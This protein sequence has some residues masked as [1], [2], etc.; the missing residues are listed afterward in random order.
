[1]ERL[2]SL[3]VGAEGA[4]DRLTELTRHSEPEIRRLA[5]ETLERIM[6]R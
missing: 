3:G 6:L 2:S 1:M 4:I 5:T